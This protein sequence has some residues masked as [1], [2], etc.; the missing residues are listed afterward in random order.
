MTGEDELSPPKGAALRR[1]AVRVLLIAHHDAFAR[2]M[3]RWS[4]A[5]QKQEGC[6]PIIDLGAP[7]FERHF[8]AARKANI[9][10]VR[11]VQAS[12]T[13]DNQLTFGLKWHGWHAVSR[14]F[15]RLYR[16]ITAVHQVMTG[17]GVRK[18]TAKI[19]QDIA[20]IRE[21]IRSQRIDIM[22]LPETSPDYGASAFL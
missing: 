6:E 18:Q 19:A 20:A 13:K 9:P 3:S 22:L 16:W 17:F 2:Q 14:R 1:I 7:Q 5:L 8:D 15:P 10:I 12:L 4:H 11:R 21:I